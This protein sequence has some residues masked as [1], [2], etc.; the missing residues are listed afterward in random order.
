MNINDLRK[1]ISEEVS[2]AVTKVFRSEIR[3]IL[4]EMLE[5]Q[6]YQD[7][8]RIVKEEEVAPNKGLSDIL[9]ETKRV[10][11]RD[12]YRNFLGDNSSVAFRPSTVLEEKK[13][14]IPGMPDF[15]ARAALQ[16]KTVLDLS[17]QKDKEKNGL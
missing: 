15:L 16:A 8:Q 12:D 4:V 3:D 9:Q 2:K 11:S 17:N 1:I 13:N 5:K 7:I 10:M 6:E 14:Y